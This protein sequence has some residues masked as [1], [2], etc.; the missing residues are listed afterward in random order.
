LSIGSCTA[1]LGPTTVVG[2]V[3]LGD[4]HVSGEG[5]GLIAVVEEGCAVDGGG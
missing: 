2:D 5:L 4:G 3:L 1:K